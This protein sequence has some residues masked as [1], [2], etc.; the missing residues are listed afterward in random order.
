MVQQRIKKKA[1]GM[2]RI[3]VAILGALAVGCIKP[4]PPAPVAQAPQRAQP[5]FQYDPPPVALSPGCKTDR[6]D[7]TGCAKNSALLSAQRDLGRLHRTQMAQMAGSLKRVH[8]LLNRVDSQP[9]VHIALSPLKTSNWTNPEG[10]Y[11][12]ELV[13]RMENGRGLDYLGSDAVDSMKS[14]MAALKQMS[15]THSAEWRE[16]KSNAPMGLVL[17][18]ELLAQRVLASVSVNLVDTTITFSVPKHLAQEYLV[19]EVSPWD[20]VAAH[21]IQEAGIRFKVLGKHRHTLVPALTVTGSSSFQIK[22]MRPARVKAT[23]VSM[24]RPVD[25]CKGLRGEVRFVRRD[26]SPA[27]RAAFR[28]VPKTGGAR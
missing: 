20:V 6:G 26:A 3:F 5:P 22:E 7:T 14:A 11:P 15:N 12:A 8:S 19:R 16:T 17:P 24:I 23:F 18:A 10:R 4:T 21:V 2:G 9:V 25:S 28:P 13:L 27:L 1:V